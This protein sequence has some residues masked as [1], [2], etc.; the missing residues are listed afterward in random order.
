MAGRAKKGMM[1]GTWWGN[2]GSIF[3]V[4][5]Y[6]C[7]HMIWFWLDMYICVYIYM[8]IYMHTILEACRF[9]LSQDCWELAEMTHTIR[10]LKHNWQCESR[11]ATLNVVG[12]GIPQKI[13]ML[14]SSI[15]IDSPVFSYSSAEARSLWRWPSRSPGEHIKRHLTRD[16]WAVGLCHH[17]P[18]VA[19]G[20][21]GPWDSEPSPRGWPILQTS[22][23]IWMKLDETPD[24]VVRQ[25]PKVA[26][27]VSIHCLESRFRSCR[28]P[29]HRG[30]EPP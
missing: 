23:Q 17:P 15:R 3:G 30:R 28:V 5:I 24:V 6:T 13:T 20:K 29:S 12:L 8:Y 25:C 2:G 14:P 11:S 10:L 7:I 1:A 19:R 22:S 16:V 27:F 26:G 4:Y 18:G 21:C 9:N